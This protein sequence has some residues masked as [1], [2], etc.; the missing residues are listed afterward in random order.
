MGGACRTNGR[1]EKRVPNFRRKAEGK[2][3]IGKPR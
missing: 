3:Q 2:T 1:D